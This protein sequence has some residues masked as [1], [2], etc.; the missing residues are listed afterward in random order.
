MKAPLF[1]TAFVF[2]LSVALTSCG[3]AEE[4]VAP[5]VTPGTTPAATTTAPTVPVTP[6]PS[7]PVPAD[8]PTYT[9]PGRKFSLRYPPTWFAEDYSLYS[10][11]PRTFDPLAVGLPPEVVKVE[12]GY[13]EAKG[14]T[15]CDT[16]SIDPATGLGTPREGATRTTLG[17]IEAWEIIR[18][19]GDGTFEGNFTQIHGIAAIHSGYCFFVTA[20]FTQAEPDTKTFLQIASSY[21][22]L[23]VTP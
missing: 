10:A 15:G 3:D 22:F 8:W 12:F 4:E 5:D 23:N 16:L 2:S 17:D 6:S 18:K 14:S 7:P 9:D 1:M 11:D 13:Y 21:R 19:A 20:Y